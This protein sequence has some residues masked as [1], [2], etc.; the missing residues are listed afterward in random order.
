MIS[1][2]AFWGICVGIFLIVVLI[3]GGNEEEDEREKY[4]KKYPHKMKDTHK[5]KG[6]KRLTK[7][8]GILRW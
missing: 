4:W 6:I 8:G 3:F 7:R 1:T 5:V 2:L